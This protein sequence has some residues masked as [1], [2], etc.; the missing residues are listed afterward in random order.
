MRP[1]GRLNHFFWTYKRLFVPGLLFAVISAGFTI[2]VPVIVRQ[3]VDSIPRFV[4]LY[5]LFEGTE[6]APQLFSQFF[7]TLMILGLI[8]IGLSLLSGVFSFLMRQTVVVA[9]RHIE[10]DLRNALY[11]HLQK[12]SQGFYHRTSTG[13]VITRA[14][15]D[16]EQV[17][18]YIGPAIMYITRASVI[19]ITAITVMLIISPTM[20]FYVL[21]PMPLLAVTVFF[22]ARLVHSR[23]EA[24]QNQYSTLTSRVQEALSGIRVLKAYTREESEAHAFEEESAAYRER[25][26]SLARVDAAWRP[27]FLLI[28]GL[29]QIIVVWVGGRLVVEGAITIGNIVE[30]IIY[31]ALM[32]WPVASM[33]F[34]ITMIQ[35]A[36]ASI[37][38]INAILDTEPAI[39]D[40][41][42]TD[43]TVTAIRGG[44]AFDHVFFRYEEDGPWVLDDVTF[45]IPA[46]AAL[47]VVGRTGSGKSTLVEMISRLL[48]PDRGA[49]HIDGRDVRD[50]PVQTL[51][52]SIGYVPQDVFLFSD[53]IAGNIAFGR[54]HAEEDAIEQA[55]YEAELLDNVRGFPKGF[56]TFVGERGITLS[57]GQKQRTS[58]ARAL[59]REP[60][61]LILDD[62]LSAVD[63]N[64]ESRILGHLRRHYG[65]RTVVIVS[66]RISA[67]QDA[68]L[69]LVLDE[70]RI[71]ERGTHDQ[72]IRGEG[73][74]ASLYRKQLLEQ[75]LEALS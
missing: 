61:I 50:L 27:V 17:R 37:I 6:A 23:S 25:M 56:E 74:Y 12:L 7:L 49:V 59:I 63:T 34:V 10:F 66:H 40:S 38:R 24:L 44:I 18:R 11:D 21:L 70:G 32:T 43:A 15:S 60:Y 4:G 57:G 20:T 5:H 65:R 52:S 35:R 45:E 69:I 64:T 22:V 39:A 46:G 16:I 8:I 26:L 53:T 54:L 47:A 51:R 72:L 48:D 36:S 28:V 30:Y 71:T 73:L 55:A 75:E 31:V 2:A 42:R 19:M 13:D 41:E 67:V 62:A 9:S 33:G 14:S 29:S 1:L 3:A 58:I 68:D